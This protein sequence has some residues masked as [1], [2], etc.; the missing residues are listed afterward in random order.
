[1]KWFL[2]DWWEDEEEVDHA[3]R[4]A[5]W[6][7]LEALRPI[8]PVAVE[9]LAFNVDLHDALVEEWDVSEGSVRAAFRWGD[10]PR[11]Y[12]SSA[13]LYAGASVLEP[14]HDVERWM[15]DEETEVL[16]D[17]ID[18]TDSD[19]F[20]HRIL[21]HPDGEL[22][23]RFRSLTIKTEQAAGRYEGLRVVESRGPFGRLRH[24]FF[25]AIA[26]AREGFRS[27]P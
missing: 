1:V 8:L 27:E 9:D 22:T 10:I 24:A 25:G 5:Y 3:R 21:L 23:I 2:R 7:H 13:L 4:A 14:L 17:E 19:D 6:E 20:E 12:R 18:V 16:Y 15:R 11:G 26:G